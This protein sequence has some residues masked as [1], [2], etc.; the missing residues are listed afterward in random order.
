MDNVSWEVER[1]GVVV[2]RGSARN[3]AGPYMFQRIGDY[4]SGAIDR[5][6]I[7]APTHMYLVS[8]PMNRELN[9]DALYVPISATAGRIGGATEPFYLQS[10]ALTTRTATVSG[11]HIEQPHGNWSMV[12]EGVF[13]AG[14]GLFNRVYLAH[15]ETIDGLRLWHQWASSETGIYKLTAETITMKWQFNIGRGRNRVALDLYG[16]NPKR[17]GC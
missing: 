12:Y 10:S 2:R 13:S 8:E 3:A 17:R 6:A 15:D 5:N 9:K 16:D 7:P 11:D 14:A 1:D 4:I